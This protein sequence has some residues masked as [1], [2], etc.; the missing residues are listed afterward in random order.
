[1]FGL[2]NSSLKPFFFMQ[3]VKE[4]DIQPLKNEN[5]YPGIYPPRA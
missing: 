5:L 1:M 2:L 4:T 3:K